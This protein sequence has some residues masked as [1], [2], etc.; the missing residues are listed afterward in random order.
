MQAAHGMGQGEEFEEAD[1]FDEYD[2]EAE[3]MEQAAEDLRSTSECASKNAS[4]QA[5]Q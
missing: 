1:E 5:A 3:A 4:P 2:E